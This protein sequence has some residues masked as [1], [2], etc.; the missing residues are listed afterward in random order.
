MSVE[1]MPTVCLFDEQ[2]MHI[3][4]YSKSAQVVTD[5]DKKKKRS[6]GASLLK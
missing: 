6:K 3:A 4:P 1:Y 2:L 5:F